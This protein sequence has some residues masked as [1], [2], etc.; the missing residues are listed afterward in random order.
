MKLTRIN[1]Y[2]LPI[3]FFFLQY[4]L[5]DIMYPMPPNET[6]YDFIVIGSG[7]AGSVIAGRLA[8]AGH[9]ILLI[10]A[11]AP[12]HWMQGIPAMGPTFLTTPYDW[13]FSYQWKREVGGKAFNDQVM[14][15][16]R[17]KSL[18]GSSM[19]NW[20]GYARGHSKDY[21]EWQKLGN[22]GWSYK[23]VLP[24]FKKSE[25]LLGNP[26][27][28]PKFHGYDGRMGVEEQIDP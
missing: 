19:L 25:R 21:D 1:N 14:T 28:S 16:P 24:Y 20:M 9:N 26:G 27:V 17:G 13:N 5:A 7:S 2:P 6:A 22:P 4:G 12:S 18:G 11:G 8:E 3:F 15:Y 23:D 10:E